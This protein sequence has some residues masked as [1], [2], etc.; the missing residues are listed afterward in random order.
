LRRSATAALIAEYRIF[1]RAQIAKAVRIFVVD[2]SAT[3]PAS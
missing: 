3:D 1:V 2:W